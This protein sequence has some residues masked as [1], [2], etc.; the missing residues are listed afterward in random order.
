M[1]SFSGLVLGHL[2]RK[3]WHTQH[4][5][6]WSAAKVLNLKNKNLS[7]TP[8]PSSRIHHQQG[9]Q[10]W[11]W[12]VLQIKLAKCRGIM[13]ESRVHSLRPHAGVVR[14]NNA[15]ATAALTPPLLGQAGET[16]KIDH[17][18][19]HTSSAIP[20]AAPP[21][22]RRRTMKMFEFP[23]C[24]AMHTHTHTFPPAHT[25][26]WARLLTA[27]GEVALC[28][29]PPAVSQSSA[30]GRLNVVWID[31]KA[32]A[33]QWTCVNSKNVVKNVI[34][35]SQLNL[36]FDR[37]A[38]LKTRDVKHYWTHLAIFFLMKYLIYTHK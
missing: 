30:A 13:H 10:G 22:S 4:D 3:R 20:R 24:S 27:R 14:I 15:G 1:S 36:S 8:C 19:S 34:R 9:V 6:K 12:S 23:K 21:L 31:L 11:R 5:L 38:L 29:A 37:C 2:C 35:S 25:S 28:S 26:A 18:R 17:A 33:L 32:L 7:S 16:H